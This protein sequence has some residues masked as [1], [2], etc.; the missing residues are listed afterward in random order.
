MTSTWNEASV[1]ST[2]DAP[3]FPV[4]VVGLDGGEA[5]VCGRRANE[6]S[7]TAPANRGE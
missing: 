1:T 2:T 3:P 5:A 4:A 6:S 7:D